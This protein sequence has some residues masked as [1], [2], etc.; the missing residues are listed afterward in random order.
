[1]TKVAGVKFIKST[2][3][4]IT[5]AKLS[6]KH[7]AKYLETIIDSAAMDKARMGET[8]SWEEA[9][10]KINKKFGFKD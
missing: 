1:M 8:E 10:K 5:H 9:K 4:K 7:H 3:G 6:M 2:S